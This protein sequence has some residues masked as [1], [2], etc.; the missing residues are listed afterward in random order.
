LIEPFLFLAKVPDPS[1]I[2]KA[3]LYVRDN[4]QTSRV[5]VVSHT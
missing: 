2:N 1:L 5:L 4:E 3:L